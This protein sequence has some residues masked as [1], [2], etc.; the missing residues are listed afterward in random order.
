MDIIKHWVSLIDE[1]GW[2]EREQILGDEARSRV[3]S[4]F[5]TQFP[6]YA[7]PP[8]LYLAIKR[9]VDR[10]GQHHSH[11]IDH[12][13]KQVTMTSLDDPHVLKNMRLENPV[14]AKAWLESVYPKLRLNWQW[15]RS[16]QRGHLA[17]FGRTASN[18][19]AYRWRGRTPDHTLTSGRLHICILFQNL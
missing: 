9:Y 14:L 4:E 15:F 5:Q 19:E 16:T 8:T 18:Q 6:H 1:N 2:I 7:N 3:P 13:E 10:L 11:G 12:S 17:R